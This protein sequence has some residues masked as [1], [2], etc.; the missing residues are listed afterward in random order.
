MSSA[1]LKLISLLCL[2]V[3]LSLCHSVSVIC[4]SLSVCL[5]NSLSL[6]LSLSLSS[7]FPHI[8][9]FCLRCSYTGLNDRAQAICMCRFESHAYFNTGPIIRCQKL[10]PL[11]LL[12]SPLGLSR[13]AWL[14]MQS[15]C[16]LKCI[17]TVFKTFLVPRYWVNVSDP[18]ILIPKYILVP[19]LVKFQWVL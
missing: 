17:V 12:D 10:C 7:T 5:S 8:L 19:N 16:P 6:S 11:D 1:F 2:S 13:P 18:L 3:R 4:L 14:Y 9:K 15:Y